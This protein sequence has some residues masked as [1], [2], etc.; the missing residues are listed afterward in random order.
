MYGWVQ[1]M[2]IEAFIPP[3]E[4]QKVMRRAHWDEEREVWVLERL[5][6]LGESWGSGAVSCMLQLSPDDSPID[7][8]RSGVVVS[9]H[10]LGQV[11]SSARLLVLMLVD[12]CNEHVLPNGTLVQAS[13]T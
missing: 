8:C 6:D 10:A 13:V 3:E 5:S 2:V 11:T 4:V 12:M 7:I 1:D 9:Q